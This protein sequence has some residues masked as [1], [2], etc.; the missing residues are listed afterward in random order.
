MVLPLHLVKLRHYTFCHY[1]HNF[2]VIISTL[3]FVLKITITSNK[4]EGKSIPL[5]QISSSQELNNNT[6]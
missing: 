5:K 1:F 2:H 6:S 3:D 4:W